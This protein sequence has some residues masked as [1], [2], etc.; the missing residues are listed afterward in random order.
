MSQRGLERNSA[1]YSR[2]LL[3]W[4]WE[5]N[6]YIRKV[7]N[8]DARGQ[9]ASIL[10]LYILICVVKRHRRKPSGLWKWYFTQAGFRPLLTGLSLVTSNAPTAVPSKWYSVG[11]LL[12]CSY[13]GQ[14]AL[15]LVLHSQVPLLQRMYL[16]YNFPLIIW[17]MFVSSLKL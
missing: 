5:T 10:R 12:E 16:N 2:F 9:S 11:S 13:L 3:T 15:L 1:P 17:V 4:L 14:L 6:G 7:R 8:W